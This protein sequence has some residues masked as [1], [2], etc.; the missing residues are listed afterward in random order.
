[1]STV[2]STASCPAYA[3]SLDGEYTSVYARAET[4]IG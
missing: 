3:T 4:I 1:M 2:G